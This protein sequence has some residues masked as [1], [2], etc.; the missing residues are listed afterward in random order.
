MGLMDLSA[1]DLSGLIAQ[2]K[3]APSEL[4]ATCLDHIAAVNPAVNAVVSL[5]DQDALMAEVGAL[6]P[7]T[8]L[9]DMLETAAYAPP[10]SIRRPDPVA[11]SDYEAWQPE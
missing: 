3:L 9:Q 1:G 5:R 2:R 10:G 7:D 11:R 8:E 4:M 6:Q